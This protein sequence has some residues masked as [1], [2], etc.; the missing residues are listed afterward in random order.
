M[1]DPV[2]LVVGKPDTVLASEFRKE[3]EP[4]L[5][6]AAEIIDRA[7]ASGLSISF[8]VSADNFGRIVVKDIAIVKPL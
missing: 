3:L 6:K 5:A 4:V 2:T 8:N 7:R 1:A